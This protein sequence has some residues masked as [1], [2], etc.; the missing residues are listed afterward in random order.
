ML[1]PV[2][3]EKVKL[4]SIQWF[5]YFYYEEKFYCLTSP[6][7]VIPFHAKHVYESGNIIPYQDERIFAED[8]DVQMAAPFSE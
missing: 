6:T 5:S 3:K 2:N 8:I 4:S 7:G 1:K